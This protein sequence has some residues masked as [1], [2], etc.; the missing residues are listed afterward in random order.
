MNLA[1]LREQPHLS[2][3]SITDYMDCGLMFKFS[4]VDRLVPEFKADALIF[5]TA[6][7]GVLAQ[8]YSP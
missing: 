8:F 5:G 2:A 7:H 6:I 3:S 1:Q 4:R